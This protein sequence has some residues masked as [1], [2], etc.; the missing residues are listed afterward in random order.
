MSVGAVQRDQPVSLVGAV[1]RE[2]DAPAIG[3]QQGVVRLAGGLRHRLRGRPGTAAVLRDHGHD[4]RA[5]AVELFPDQDHGI[6]EVEHIG[7]SGG[8]IVASEGHGIGK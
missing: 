6:V 5:R 7:M 3:Y 8:L 4:S 1:P 2:V